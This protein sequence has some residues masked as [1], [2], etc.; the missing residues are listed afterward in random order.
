MSI[1][2]SSWHTTKLAGHGRAARRSGEP[3]NAIN[4]N[5]RG[6]GTRTVRPP[7]TRPRGRSDESGYAYLMALFMVLMV[8]VGS[9]VLLTDAATQAQ[10][11]REDEMMWRGKQYVR[12][13]KLYYRKTGHYPLSLDDLEKGVANIH[14]L[15]RPYKDPMNKNEDGKW[16]FIYT[17]ATGQIIGSVRYASMQQ[18]AILDLNGGIIPGAP[19]SDSSQDSNVTPVP[20]PDQGASSGNCPPA[21]GANGAG[22]PAPGSG[23]GTT[24]SSNANQPQS[25]SPQAVCPPN[26]GQS[27][28]PQQGGGLF[29]GLLGQGQGQPGGAQLGAGLQAQQLQALAQMKPTGPVDSPVIG[30][31][32]VGVGGGTKDDTKSV[33]VY[34]RAKKYKDWEFIWNPLE[35]QARAV[36]QGMNQ[37]GAGGLLGQPNGIGGALGSMPG[38]PGSTSTSPGQPPT[39]TSPTGPPQ[40]P[41]QPQ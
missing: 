23:I 2:R 8:I 12:A 4:V 27:A 19:A 34:K 3:V 1:K 36:Q 14:F 29:G 33:K 31:F 25:S 10:R 26:Q 15:R 30:G 38:G 24:N 21:I 22:N 28:N 20:Q 5:H 32:I 16:R 18:M 39:G 37:A 7:R 35:D 17:N 40:P 41:Q 6:S 11:Q 9:L 13:I